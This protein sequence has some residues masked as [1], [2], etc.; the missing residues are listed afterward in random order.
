[1]APLRAP[2]RRRSTTA[3]AAL[4]GLAL[5]AGALVASACDGNGAAPPQAPAEPTPIEATAAAPPPSD[6]SAVVTATAE[7]QSPAL[8]APN[9]TVEVGPAPDAPATL[10]SDP[11]IYVKPREVRQGYSFLVAVDAPGAGFASVAYNGQVFTLLREG[12]RLYTIL[13]VDALTPP[14][15][16][17]VVIAVADAQGRPAVERETLITVTDAFFPTEVVQLD[18]SNQALL[19]SEILREDLETRTPVVQRVTPERHW[20]GIF[21]PPAAG[22]ITSGYGLLRSYNYAAPIEYHTGLDFAGENG[23]PILAP[24][25]GVVAWVGQTRRRGNGIILDHGGGVYTGYYHLSEV[26]V[27]VGDVVSTGDALGRIGATGLATGP[28][29][30]WEV[31]VH[32]VTVDPVQWLRDREIPDPTATLDPA[33]ALPASPTQAAAQ[34]R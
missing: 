10:E 12:D 25:A 11:L 23:A 16:I 28:H 3:A 4:V 20:S 1:M 14:G 9:S 24:N 18:S 22:V 17:P 29:L 15:P 34:L 8:P 7:E 2:I 5:L 27:K 26:L 30:H 13:P 33:T 31:V 6:E 21:E 32:G 19:D